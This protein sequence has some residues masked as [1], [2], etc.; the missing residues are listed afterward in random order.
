MSPIV[1]FVLGSI[2]LPLALNEVGEL[3]PRLAR[4][5]LR[6]GARRLGEPAK[7]ARY[8][9]EWLADLQ[10]VDGKLSKL[11]WAIGVVLLGI[12]RLRTPRPPL[13]WQAEEAPALRVPFAGDSVFGAGDAYFDRATTSRAPALPGPPA[14][15]RSPEEPSHRC[16]AWCDAF[17]TQGQRSAPPVVGVD[18]GHHQQRR[19]DP[20]PPQPWRG[21]DEEH[22]QLPYGQRFYRNYAEN[23]FD[24]P[25]RRRV[26]LEGK[27]EDIFGRP[28]RTSLPVI[29][30]D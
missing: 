23:N 20:P 24:Q 5:L 13:D 22:S 6:W 29:G 17:C 21:R 3:A 15:R 12:A 26:R 2:L 30:T 4:G 9:E 27:T 14:P 25:Y 1:L 7:T 16:T 8:T 11:T 18:I 28:D 10:H 19:V